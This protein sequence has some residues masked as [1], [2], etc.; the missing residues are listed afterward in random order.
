MDLFRPTVFFRPKTISK[1]VIIKT[2]SATIAFFSSPP[3]LLVALF[4]ISFCFVTVI[5]ELLGLRNR[6]FDAFS[7]KW[8][9]ILLGWFSKNRW[10]VCIEF[11]QPFKLFHFEVANDLSGHLVSTLLISH[12]LF[13][14]KISANLSKCAIFKWQM[15]FQAIWHQRCLFRGIFKQDILERYRQ[16]DLFRP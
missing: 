4:L 8:L 6:P 5:L 7:L 9:Q 1:V 14:L 16:M 13:F 3:F 10:D 12:N 2:E 11:C 15:T